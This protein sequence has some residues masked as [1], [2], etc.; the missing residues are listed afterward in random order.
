MKTSYIYLLM[1][2]LLMACSDK[3]SDESLTKFTKKNEIINNPQSDFFETELK[4]NKLSATTAI[5]SFIN[6]TIYDDLLKPQ[7]KIDFAES[8]I[9]SKYFK[10][11]S[12]KLYD[13]VFA[14]LGFNYIALEKYKDATYYFEYSLDNYILQL[15]KDPKLYM[16]I[17][18]DLAYCYSEIYKNDL[19]LHYTEKGIKIGQKYPNKVNQ[20]DLITAYN[21]SLYF[22]NNQQFD[23][24]FQIFDQAKKEFLDTITFIDPKTKDYK[25]I[26]YKKFEIQHLLVK[27]DSI[28]ALKN[29]NLFAKYQPEHKEMTHEKNNYFL[30]TFS[31]VVDFYLFNYKSY[32]KALDLANQFYNISLSYPE[33]PH[34]QMLALSKI[35]NAQKELK[36][37]ESSIQTLDLLENKINP[38]LKYSSYYSLKIIRAINLSKLKKDKEVVNLLDELFP[39]L[40]ENLMNKEI[41]IK[42]LH[43]EEYKDFN[44]PYIVNIF[45]TASYLY[46]QAYLSDK[47]L[48]HLDK[49]ESLV[50]SALKMFAHNHNHIDNSEGLLSYENNVNETLLFLSKYKYKNNKAKQKMCIEALEKN[51]SHQLF[52]QFQNQVI[53]NNSEL[54]KLYLVKNKRLARIERLEDQLLFELNNNLLKEKEKTENE[55]REINAKIKIGLKNFSSVYEDFSI[56]RLQNKLTKNE[57]IVKYYVAKE[58]VYRLIITKNNIDITLIG[59]IEAVQVEVQDYL[60]KIKNPSKHYNQK[61]KKLFQMLCEDIHEKHL[62]IIPQSFMNYLPFETLLNNKN[63][64]WV[65]DKTIHYNFSLPIWYG[66]R[67]YDIKNTK[68]KTLS[69]AADYSNSKNGS[70]QLNHAQK[71]IE[72]ITEI[73][74]G[75]K[76]N[77]ATVNDF[78]ENVDTHHVYHLAMHAKLDDVNFEESSVLFSHDEPLYFKDFYHLNIPLDLVVL[79]ACNTGNGKLI[80]GDGIMSLSRALTF[81]GVKSSVVSYWEVP[82]KETADLMALFY[83]NLKK[84]RQKSDA[85]SLAKRT[86]IEKYPLK[87]HPYFWAG[88]VL[89]GNNE[90]VYKDYSIYYLLG[91]F[92]ILI[93]SIILIRKNYFNKFKS[94]E[95]DFLN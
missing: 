20:N 62:N 21:N 85:L 56:A 75:K 9:Q 33:L 14:S 76:I 30:S 18:L 80:N 50:F 37:Y 83:A 19:L 47:N 17:N 89:N 39:V 95:A 87:N 84:G 24:N 29:L 58:R 44:S 52:N 8:L 42:N 6:Q 71:E 61:S 1:L 69:L 48:E 22:S 59:D 73:T 51:A 92:I 25:D 28:N 35:S 3:K 4:K 68:N 31:N 88:F 77:E 78:L 16:S 90:V 2:T 82:D 7:Y 63:I 74:K 5:D 26:V 57:N 94:S 70:V 60:S 13:D 81:S 66:G 38:N 91:G 67:I 36:Q 27:N 54:K 64:P 49:A 65:F 43:E 86:F 12:Q 46:C 72:K 41:D 79:S 45:S 32:A 34:Y 11:I 55:V 10:N 53:I 40:T 93:I 15:Q 23:K